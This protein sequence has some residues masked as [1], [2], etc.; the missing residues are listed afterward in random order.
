ML[1]IAVALVLGQVPAEKLAPV[2]DVNQLKP[3]QSTV[4]AEIDTEKVQGDPIGLA[5][6]A[7][8]VIYLRVLSGKDRARHYQIATRPKLSVAQSD[9]APEWAAKYWIWKS[10][11]AAPGDDT[12]KMEVE[13]RS[14]RTRMLNTPGGG[15]LAGTAS[16]A[17]VG[18][19]GGEGV[20]EG[21]ALQAANNS[22][23]SAI[24]TLHFKGQVVG[25]WTNEV[26]RLGMRF[27]WA[28]AGVGL[29]AYTDAE[30]QLLVIDRE[31]RKLAIPGA[32]KALLPAWSLDGTQLLYLQKKSRTEYAI[33][34][35]TL[36]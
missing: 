34:L 31:G 10:A 25:E 14:D 5:W 1:A 33:T 24:V 29:L 4:I 2:T 35:V 22:V 6:S 20:S 8:G 26:P 36:R 12:L 16:A 18:G 13:Q 9:G 19:G 15:G 7:D 21:L 28:P 11:T 30:G 17:M 23:T 27:G 32:T 3:G